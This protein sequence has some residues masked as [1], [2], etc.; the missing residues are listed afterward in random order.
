MMLLNLGYSFFSRSCFVNNLVD[1]D[2]L[3]VVEFMMKGVP[4]VGV[5]D[6][7]PCYPERL[8]PAT[9]TEED[10]RRSAIWRRTAS[11][12]SMMIRMVRG[13]GMASGQEEGFVSCFEGLLSTGFG[14]VSFS[15]LGRF[16]FAHCMCIVL[17]LSFSVCQLLVW[18]L[19][20]QSAVST[21]CCF[22]THPPI[23]FP[24][25]LGEGVEKD[26]SSVSFYPPHEKEFALREFC[27][28]Q[29]LGGWVPSMVFLDLEVAF[30]LWMSC[31]SFPACWSFVGYLHSVV[32]VHDCFC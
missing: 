16:A 15:F 21:A 24:S 18:V 29:S 3:G 12:K 2:D 1:Y 6:T 9:L 14:L 26:F 10:L 20:W 17:C 19:H 27:V 8:R 13:S 5:H 28:S 22:P 32:K 23:C 4:L 31:I 25:V 11:R 7:P 30:T